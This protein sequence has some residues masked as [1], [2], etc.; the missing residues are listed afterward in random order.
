VIPLEE[1][2]NGVEGMTYSF[3]GRQ[4]D[5]SANISVYF[6]LGTDPDIAA[7]NVQNRVKSNQ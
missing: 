2:I 5:S 7:V 4:N 6:G 1:E 3:N